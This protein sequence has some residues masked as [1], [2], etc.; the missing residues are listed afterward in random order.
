[1]PIQYIYLCDKWWFYTWTSWTLPWNGIVDIV[2]LHVGFDPKNTILWFIIDCSQF[3]LL[4]SLIKVKG[5]AANL[6]AF[7][8]AQELISVNNTRSVMFAC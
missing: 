6:S 4:C 3:A 8:A 1:M 5:F 7:D 2:N